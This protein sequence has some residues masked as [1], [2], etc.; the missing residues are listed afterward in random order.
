MPAK[1]GPPSGLR[2]SVDTAI[3]APPRNTCCLQADKIA[4]A[5][6][7]ARPRKL[8]TS[9]S[10]EHH[11]I[12]EAI[13]ELLRMEPDQKAVKASYHSRPPRF[14][15]LQLNFRVDNDSLQ[16]IDLSSKDGAPE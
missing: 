16:A 13:P 1:S 14:G 5:K 3:P 11:L 9:S 8:E 15:G 2:R 7:D 4:S 10:I 6:S 12:P